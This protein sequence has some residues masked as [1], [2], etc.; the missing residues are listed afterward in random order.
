VSSPRR[1]AGAAGVVI[2]E[3]IGVVRM[4]LRMLF[5]SV[6]DIEVLGEA[7]DADAALE[8]VS[9]I[10]GPSGVVVLLGV[11]LG[12]EHD[13]FWLIRAI[14][15][16]SP[17]LT[18]LATG[19]DLSPSAIS[20]ALFA[21]ADGFVHKNSS[22]E[23]YIEATRRA[24]QGELVLEGLP[25][26]ALGGIVERFDHQRVSTSVLTPREH[27]VLVAAA[28]GLTAREMARRLGVRE[29]TVT[30]HLN[31]IYRKLGASGRIAAVTAAARMGVLTL[32]TSEVVV[33]ADVVPT[34][35]VI[36]ALSSADAGSVASN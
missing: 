30:T 13:S 35:E 23:R 17:Q 20:Q 7:S 12:G 32:P 6:P 11:E 27:M 10:K 34:L 31:H 28:D 22:P 29:R 5:E 15:G 19:T 36:G 18:I 2:V 9:G 1:T 25:R 33:T 4:S 24:A 8:V 14:R 21:G 16:A 26:G 3:A